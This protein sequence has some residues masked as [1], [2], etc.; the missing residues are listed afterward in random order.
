MLCYFELPSLMDWTQLRNVCLYFCFVVN[1]ELLS[2]ELYGTAG[3][4]TNETIKKA[5]QGDHLPSSYRT[6][7]TQMVSILTICPNEILHLTKWLNSD[8]IIFIVAHNR[9]SFFFFLLNGHIAIHSIIL[10]NDNSQ[11]HLQ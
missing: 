3:M 6:S 11:N 2:N 4:W 5:V 7:W 9:V 8:Q 1:D 10:H